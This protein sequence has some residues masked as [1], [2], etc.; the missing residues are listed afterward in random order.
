MSDEQ[1]KRNW[2]LI[3]FSALAGGGLIL[4]SIKGAYGPSQRFGMIAIGI[5]LLI[6]AAH[7][8]GLFGRPPGR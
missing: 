5:A 4:T 6:H 8:M 3:A 1:T 7:Y 2:P